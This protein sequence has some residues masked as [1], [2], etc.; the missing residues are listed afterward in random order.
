MILNLQ[1]RQLGLVNSY[2]NA[3]FYLQSLFSLNLYIAKPSTSVQSENKITV[4]SI[5][6]HLDIR[7]YINYTL[8]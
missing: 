8:E 5:W 1:N 3:V 7:Q 4:V 6:E 2:E